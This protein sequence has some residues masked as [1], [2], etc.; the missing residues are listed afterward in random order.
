MLPGQVQLLYLAT[1]RDDR[2]LDGRDTG[3]ADHVGRSD[4]TVGAY[5]RLLLN[6]TRAAFVTEIH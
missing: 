3:G 5:A 6:S 2:R 4:Y 1:V